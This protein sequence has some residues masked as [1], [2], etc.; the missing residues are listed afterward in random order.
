MENV[1]EKYRNMSTE[2][3]VELEKEIDMR[4]QKLEKL[5]GEGTDEMFEWLVEDFELGVR[6]GIMLGELT[7]RMMGEERYRE[8]MMDLLPVLNEQKKKVER[9][10]EAMGINW[11]P[12][13]EIPNPW[14]L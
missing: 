3:L 9:Y 8:F 10:A 1:L 11:K 14:E 4:I 6:K 7:R 2:E 5:K 12:N 13:V